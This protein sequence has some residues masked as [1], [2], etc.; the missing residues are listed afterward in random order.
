VIG[1][2]TKFG[3]L[4]GRDAIYLH[5]VVFL[6]ESEI[7]LKGEINS[8]NTINFTLRFD[9]VV[10]FSSLELDFDERTQ[11]ESFCIVENS[12]K[13]MRYWKLDHSSKLNDKHKH[14]YVRT[15]DTVFEI[16][17][18]HFYFSIVN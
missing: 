10:Y 6:G 11:M 4:I 3:F 17:S 9:N 16:I 15:Y 7:L 14:Y 5:E 2:K 12:E 8:E 18:D 1:I 13:L